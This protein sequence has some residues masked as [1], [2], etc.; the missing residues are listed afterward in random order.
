MIDW[1][2]VREEGRIQLVVASQQDVEDYL[3]ISKLP[4]ARVVSTFDF[5]ENWTV[6]GVSYDPQRRAFVFAVMSPEFV[7]TTLGEMPEEI[8]ADRHT[9]EITRKAVSA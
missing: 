7:P 1:I 4:D 2:K 6:S 9:I 8:L 5:P 3:L